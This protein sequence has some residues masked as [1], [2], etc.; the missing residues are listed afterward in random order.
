MKRT[1]VKKLELKR[2]TVKQLTEVSGAGCQVITRVCSN[3]CSCTTTQICNDFV[4]V[5]GYACCDNPACGGAC[6]APQGG[7]GGC[8]GCG[9][10]DLQASNVMC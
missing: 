2:L 10:G 9:G 8:G 4:E 7:G 5:P 3:T 1:G 6:L